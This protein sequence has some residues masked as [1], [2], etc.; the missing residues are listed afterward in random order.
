MRLIVGLPLICMLAMLVFSLPSLAE[1]QTPLDLLQP[2]VPRC[3]VD[4]HNVSP[5]SALAID[6]TNSELT[7]WQDNPL[8]DIGRLYNGVR[9]L[10]NG[11]A[12]VPE[13]LT[14]FSQS[15]DALP[16]NVSGGLGNLT[17]VAV[18]DKGLIFI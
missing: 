10:D 6:A 14:N 3:V 8:P 2:K 16:Q 13:T 4:L 17:P 7:A 12:G 9:E 5:S 18:E 15:N 1:S 11:Q